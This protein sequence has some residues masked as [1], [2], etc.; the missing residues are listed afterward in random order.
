MSI[1]IRDAEPA[2]YPRFARAARET[3]AH[4]VAAVPNVFR[5]ADPAITQSYFEER[6]Q[7]TDTDVFVAVDGGEIVGYAIMRL[8]RAELPILVPRTA[9][10]VENFGVLAAYRRRGVGRLIF[11]RCEDRARQRGAQTLELECWEANQEALHFYAALGMRTQRRRLE[12]D[13]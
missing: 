12:V 4:H 10:L 11:A 1:Q 8:R 13:L 5:D 9:T 6:L 3:L 7:D 2:D